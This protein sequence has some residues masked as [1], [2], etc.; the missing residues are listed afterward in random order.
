[1][2]ISV[3]VFTTGIYAQSSSSSIH[4]RT[5]DL[6]EKALSFKLT[7]EQFELIKDEAYANPKFVTGTIYQDETPIKTGVPMRYNAHADEIEIE[8]GPSSYSALTKDPSIFVK[9]GPDVYVFA[10]FEGSRERGGYFNV[11][12]EG[13]RYNLYKK[14]TSVFR[15]AKPAASTYAR[16]TPPSF[17][18]STVYYLVDNGTF[19]EMPKGKSRIMK[20]MDGKR[21]EINDF[22][23]V[24]KLDIDKEDDLIK[25][26]AYFDS[27]Q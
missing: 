5:I 22:V 10:P 12:H 8:S 16:D 19:L 25:V 26:I 6:N 20:M 27:L 17:Q 2:M 21:K 4:T 14:V 11:L 18:K 15:E 24:N 3:A 9:I 13:K 7:E 1:M 23:K